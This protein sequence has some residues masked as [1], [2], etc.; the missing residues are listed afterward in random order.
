MSTCFPYYQKTKVEL[1]I[2]YI[3]VTSVR[4]LAYSMGSHLLISALGRRILES[5][6]EMHRLVFAAA[7]SLQQSFC[8]LSEQKVG[9]VMHKCVLLTSSEDGRLCRP[10]NHQEQ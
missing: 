9:A 2:E 8:R 3:Q 4:V 10:G 7:D 5:G 6:L 1:C